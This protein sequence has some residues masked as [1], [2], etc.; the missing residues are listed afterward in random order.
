MCLQLDD[1]DGA[2]D[3]GY[4]DSLSADA[5]LSDADA[6]AADDDR[7]DNGNGQW[8]FGDQAAL[9]SFRKR[10]FAPVLTDQF[11]VATGDPADDANDDRDIAGQQQ[12]PRNLME[13]LSSSSSSA[14][15][16]ALYESIIDAAVASQ[17]G[18]DFA[19]EEDADDDD[20]D[21]Q[22]GPDMNFSLPANL[23]AKFE[24]Q[25]RLD[26]KKP[27]PMYAVNNFAFDRS[28]AAAAA[29]EAE[30]D[31]QDLL[32]EMKQRNLVGDE[33]Y[34]I[35]YDNDGDG[36]GDDQPPQD[37]PTSRDYRKKPVLGADEWHRLER[38]QLVERINMINQEEIEDEKQQQQLQQK[39]KEEVAAA[40]LQSP[41]SQV[42]T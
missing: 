26:V 39:V 1:S 24:R 5:Y 28:A 10:K 7:A 38:Q 37:V 35:D 33:G 14:S 6:P 17:G 8:H 11:L 23:L 42:I 40:Q 3:G 27:G 18:R 9:S 15:D 41:S 16:K 12:L 2:I 4:Q 29:A 20:Q 13:M 32:G 36:D 25:E 22:E 30:A 21:D 19:D 34:G 31:A